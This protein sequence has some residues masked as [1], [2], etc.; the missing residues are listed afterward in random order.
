[1]FIGRD[2]LVNRMGPRGGSWRYMEFVELSNRLEISLEVYKG[3]L[4]EEPLRLNIDKKP[5][6]ISK[7]TKSLILILKL[8]RD[9]AGILGIPWALPV[10]VCG[11]RRRPQG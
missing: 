5:T 10:S 8:P 4:A 3:K 9:L 1:M 6:E 11:A 2:S 7:I